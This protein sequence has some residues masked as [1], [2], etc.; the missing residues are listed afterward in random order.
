MNLLCV[1]GDALLNTDNGWVKQYN[2][3]ITMN[4]YELFQEP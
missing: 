2:I 4:V 1:V 3:A